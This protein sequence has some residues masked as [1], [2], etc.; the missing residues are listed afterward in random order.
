[1]VGIEADWPD[2]AGIDRYVRGRPALAMDEQNFSRFPTW[3]WRN[4]ETQEFV[5]WLHD[6]NDRRGSE[7][8]VAF[9]GLD[10]YSL[11]RSIAEVVHYLA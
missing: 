8:R 9:Y 10:L 11:Y 6:F 3:M 7:D 4:V 2:A 1:M 5:D